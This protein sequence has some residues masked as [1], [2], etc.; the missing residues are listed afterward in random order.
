MTFKN[1]IGVSARVLKKTKNQLN[2]KFNNNGEGNKNGLSK[3][4]IEESSEDDSGTEEVVDEMNKL[5]IQL[6]NDTS[7]NESNKK[8]KFKSDSN[9]LG[10]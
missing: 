9:S 10:K 8:E 6:E 3:E 2:I 1:L 5:D 7:E 4:L